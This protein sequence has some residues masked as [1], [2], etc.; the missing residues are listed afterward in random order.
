[1]TDTTDAAPAALDLKDAPFTF[2]TIGAIANTEFVPRGL[3]GKPDKILASILYG[4]EIGLPPMQALNQVH[5][6]DG[7]PTPSA[8]LLTARI[9][10]AGHRIRAEELTAETATVIGERINEEGEVIE[11]MTFTY[12][13]GMAKRAGLTGK[14]NWKKYPEAMLYW[15]ATSQ[16]ARMFFADLLIGFY[17]GEELGS[18]D[19]HMEPAPF[20]EEYEDLEVVETEIVEDDEGEDRMMEGDS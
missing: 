5:I 15:R 14:D 1:M 13:I 10:M 2:K 17:T 4:R 8:E 19:W 16:L 20:D 12:D 18:A 9:R 6:I 7:K 3:R 11:T